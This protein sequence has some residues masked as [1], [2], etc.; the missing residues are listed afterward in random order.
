MIKLF[1]NIQQNFIIFTS[2][3]QL[4]FDKF[5]PER[6]LCLFLRIACIGAVGKLRTDSRGFLGIRLL[7]PEDKTVN[8]K[9]E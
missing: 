8:K 6:R 9:L 2:I 3:S 5:F 1:C 4:A 7:N